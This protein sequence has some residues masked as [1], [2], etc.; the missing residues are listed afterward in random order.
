MKIFK[1]NNISWVNIN[2]FQQNSKSLGKD[3][4]YGICKVVNNQS[5]GIMN[6]YLIHKERKNISSF[7]L[8]IPCIY[9]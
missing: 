6:I 9:K 7:I 2:R 8:Y 3:K 4:I 5:K 1:K